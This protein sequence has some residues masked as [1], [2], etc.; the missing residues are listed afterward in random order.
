MFVVLSDFASASWDVE[1]LLEETSSTSLVVQTTGMD[2]MELHNCFQFLEN[3]APK[4]E[5]E[6]K[7]KKISFETN[8]VQFAAGHYKLI[9]VLVGSDYT[10]KER[11]FQLFIDGSMNQSESDSARFDCC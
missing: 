2:A 7:C 8:Q 3:F 6:E 1:L 5:E 10:E 9:V 11:S 4:V